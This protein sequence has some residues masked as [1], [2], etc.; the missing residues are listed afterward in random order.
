MCGVQAPADQ[1]PRPQLRLEDRHVP[2]ELQRCCSCCSPCPN[3]ALTG[4]LLQLSKALVPAVH[5]A[6][7]LQH[8]FGSDHCPAGLTLKLAELPSSAA[9]APAEDGKEVDEAA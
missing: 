4:G 3:Q 8:V 1:S 9:P 7:Q 2:G 6:F 5:D